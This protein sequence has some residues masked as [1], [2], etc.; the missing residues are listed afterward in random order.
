MREKQNNNTLSVRLDDLLEFEPITDNQRVAFE[1]WHEGFNMILSGCAGTG[2]TFIALYLA[3]ETILDDDTDQDNIVI[4]RST[5]PVRDQGFLPGTKKEKEDPYTAV[6]KQIGDELFGDNKT[7]NKAVSAK[8]V[9]FDTTSYLR[10]ITWRNSVVIVDEMQNLNFQELDTVMTRLGRNSRII[11][12]GDYKQ[13]DFKYNDEK[14]GLFQF[15][16][17]VE[18]LNMFKIVNF[19]WDDI[20]RSGVVRDYLMTKEM[21]GK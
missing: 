6:Y 1:A 2:K 18:H 5:V 11:F 3:L 16:E 15:T 13:T 19:G 14:E 4:I 9:L 8:R 17:I 20:V 7:Y 12:C 21:L 10:G